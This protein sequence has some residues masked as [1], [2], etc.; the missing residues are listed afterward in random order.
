MKN[1]FIA[2]IKLATRHQQSEKK[3][4]NVFYVYKFNISTNTRDH[5]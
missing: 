1:V 2:T 5:K 4:M 3:L